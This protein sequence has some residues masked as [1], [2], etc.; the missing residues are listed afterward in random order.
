MKKGMKRLT[1]LGTVMMFLLCGCAKQELPEEEAAQPAVGTDTQITEEAETEKIPLR[2]HIS[3]NQKSYYTEGSEE[4][5]MDLTYCD[6][7]VEGDG[8]DNLKRNIEQWSLERSEE[9]RGMYSEYEEIDGVTSTL[10]QSL[11]TT[12]A[13]TSLVCLLEEVYEYSGGAHG[14]DYRKGVT[15]DTQSGRQLSLRDISTDYDTFAAEAVKRIVYELKEEYEE[16]LFTDYEETVRTMWQEETVSWYLD[17]AGIVIVF[18]QYSVGPYA[19]GMAEV[20]LPYAELEPYIKTAYLPT[21]SDGVALMAPN[22]EVFVKLPATGQKESIQLISEYRDEEL[23]ATLFFGDMGMQFPGYANLG[24]TY[25]VRHDGEIYCLVEIDMA[26]DDYMTDVFRL[27][28]GNLESISAIEGAIDEKNVNSDSIDLERWV[29]ILGT[30]GGTKTYHFAENGML[31]TEDT[32]YELKNNAYVLTTKT[33]IPV[34]IDDTENTLPAGSRIILTAT[35]GE[36][37]VK[38]TIQETGQNGKMLLSRTE[39]GFAFEIVDG[40]TEY[41]CFEVVPYAG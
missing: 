12:R 34:T 1:F 36:S 20:C 14:M 33:G 18:E 3:E 8:Y 39:D 31:V 29:Y 7:T 30:Y 35:D 19:M 38:F 25:L 10:S 2:I 26:S 15:F 27:T 23:Y 37:Y 9:L 16:A 22:E 13:D 41:D 24:D 40:K 6:V 28:D 11:K 21:E 5:Y 4:A 32:E 17:A